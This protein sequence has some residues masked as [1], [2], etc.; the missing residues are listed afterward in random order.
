MSKHL[1]ILGGGIAGTTAAEELRKRDPEAA[2]TIIEAEAH[3]CYSRVLLP[4]YLKGK[5]PREKVF[6][7][8]F[9]SYAKQN[10]EL[11]ANTRAEEIDV[12]NRFVRISDGR[13]LPFDQLLLAT[14]GELNLAPEDRRGVVYLRG[15]DDADHI[16]SLSREVAMKPEGQRHAVVLGGGFI[17]L[18]FMNYFAHLGLPT[19]VLMRGSGFWSSVLSSSS[20]QLLVDHARKHGVVVKT[21]VKAIALEGDR[22]LE[23]VVVDGE[24]LP[25]DILGVGIGIRPDRELFERAGIELGRGIRVD[26]RL[27]SNRDGVFA[28]GDA[29]EFF[30]VI[31]G[32]H[33]VYGNWMNAQMQG[34]AVA[35]SMMGDEKPF[36]LVSSYATELLG[37]HVVFIGDADP[38][39]ADRVD[40][41]ESHAGVTERFYRQGKLVGAALV[42]DI[43][44]RMA[45]TAEIRG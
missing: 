37:L 24:A 25:A 9:E 4:H 26:E 12:V 40:V 17:G 5:I 15:V 45:I 2:I 8:S 41:R 44:G 13:E 1:V 32:R 16:L 31:V 34:R 30:D 20:Q 18:E 35:G 22:Q 3:P 29:A 14:G 36:S 11:L 38:K 23:S 43:E 39:A 6:L 10:I 19:T 28:A 27:A 7:R 33:V 42:G 21:Q